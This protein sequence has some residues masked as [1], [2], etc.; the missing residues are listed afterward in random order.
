MR[1]KRFRQVERKKCNACNLP[2]LGIDE[3][4]HKGIDFCWCGEQM[5]IEDLCKTVLDL[6][7]YAKRPRA[8]IDPAKGLA[9]HLYTCEASRSVLVLAKVVLRMKEALEDI[10]DKRRINPYIPEPG[11]SHFIA[12]IGKARAALCDINKIVKEN[13]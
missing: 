1:D 10:A 3:P 8:L 7:D 9:M 6:H 4:R 5:N 11:E 13:K 2:M 12:L